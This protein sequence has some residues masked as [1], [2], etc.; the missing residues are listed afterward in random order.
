MNWSY[1]ISESQEET[2]SDLWFEVLVQSIPKRTI[3]DD[4]KKVATV[5]GYRR[6]VTIENL[7]PNYQ[8]L[9]QVVGVNSMG[10]GP[11]SDSSIVVQTHKL[12]EIH[13]IDEQDEQDSLSEQLEAKPKVNKIKTLLKK[14]A[15]W[16]VD[17]IMFE[18]LTETERQLE[19]LN[20]SNVAQV[21]EESDLGVQN[22]S[23]DPLEDSKD[24]ENK[25][26]SY[27]FFVFHALQSNSL[28]IVSL[29]FVLNFFANGTILSVVYPIGLFIAIVVESPRPSRKL[30]TF[31][32]IYATIVIVMKFLFQLP[33]FCLQS[34]DGLFYYYSIQPWCPDSINLSS[35]DVIQP[36]RII[37]LYKIKQTDMNDNVIG[38]M[39][40]H[41]VWDL[42]VLLALQLHR[43]SLQVWFN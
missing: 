40:S 37:G 16:L 34:S 28:A 25:Y 13:C 18:P 23:G 3:F 33:V 26:T 35:F 11:V 39:W 15:Y 36:I 2:Q 17:D 8:Y 6:S 1:S 31:F 41:M 38:L 21:C 14:I 24:T 27:L 4:F 43:N 9:F 12:E 5:P 30:W 19:K 22:K 10:Y 7:S 20:A 32:F 42:F 29:A